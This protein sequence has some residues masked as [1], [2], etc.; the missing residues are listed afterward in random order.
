MYGPEKPVGA[1]GGGVLALFLAGAVPM[2]PLGEDCRYERGKFLLS[3][4]MLFFAGCVR[5]RMQQRIGWSGDRACPIVTVFVTPWDV[6]LGCRAGMWVA[7]APES[8]VRDR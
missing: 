7:T 3:R 1:A 6:T 2:L 5:L 8:P 4:D